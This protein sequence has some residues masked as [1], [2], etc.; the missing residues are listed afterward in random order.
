MLKDKILAALRAAEKPLSGAQLCKELGVSRAAV[1]KGVT[2]LRKEGYE[3]DAQTSVGYRLVSAPD[4]LTSADLQ[5]TRPLPP[6]YPPSTRPLPP[7]HPPSTDPLPTLYSPSTPPLLP[8][9]REVVCLDT[10]DSTND[11]VKRRALAG[12]E[13]GLVVTAEQQTAG[14]GRRGRSF[15]SLSGKGLYLSVLLKP[16]VPLSQVSQLTAWTA[17]AVCRSIEGICDVKP[18]IKWPN[19]ILA[20]GKKLC[21]ILTEMGV[22]GETGALSYVVVGMGTNVSQTRADFGEKLLEIATSLHILGANVTRLDLARALIVELDRMNAAFP[23]GREEYLEEYKKRCVTLGKEVKIIR[24]D[25]ETTAT[26]EGLT[27][28]FKLVARHRDGTAEEVSSG[29]VSVRGLLGYQ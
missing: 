2:A 21:G 9:G 19:D 1:W 3:I 15:Q 20:G 10:V 7:L 12:A 5:F 16:K 23:L 18:Q 22:E 25:G 26:A 4:R 6:L 13:A 11:E 17:V 8:V 28:D 27:E 29:E 14:K 24:S